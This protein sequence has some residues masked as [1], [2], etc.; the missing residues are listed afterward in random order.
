MNAGPQPQPGAALRCGACGGAVQAEPWEVHV[1]CGY[2]GAQ[3]QV[4]ARPDPFTM[5]AGI[6]VTARRPWW[7]WVVVAAGLGL[8][9]AHWVS[10]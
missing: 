2:C 4:R 5:S 7:P 10:G 1:R 8:A 3:T 9:V 6:E